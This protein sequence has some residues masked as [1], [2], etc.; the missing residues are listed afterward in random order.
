[1]LPWAIAAGAL[2]A[3]LAVAIYPRMDRPG[4]LAAPAAG[5]PITGTTT[6]GTGIDLS[7]MTEREAADRLFNRVMQHVSDGDSAQARQFLPMALAA[8]QRVDDLDRDGHYHVAVL[9]LVNG[10]PTGARAHADTIL[11]EEPDHLFGLASAAQA[12]MM[13]GNESEGRAFFRRFLE[14]YDTESQRPL[15]EY[16]EHRPVIPA[17]REEALQAVRD[18]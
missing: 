17:I 6:G 12:E 14:V 8:Y 3:L 5:P 13:R 4:D 16:A 2:A 1:M 9:E 11:A 18:P 7:S 15:P 10:N